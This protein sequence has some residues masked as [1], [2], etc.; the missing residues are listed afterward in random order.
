[1][2]IYDPVAN[3]QI[4]ME[5]ADTLPATTGGFTPVK[6][7]TKGTWFVA[8][9]WTNESFHIDRLPE[10]E[11]NRVRFRIDTHL[12]QE[13]LETRC[14]WLKRGDTVPVIAEAKVTNILSRL[15]PGVCAVV[16]KAL[17]AE[18]YTREVIGQAY[19]L[20]EWEPNDGLTG[21]EVVDME[22]DD[23]DDR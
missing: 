9:V 16:E 10:H 22:A 19:T 14:R 15:D 20:L 3:C 23:A 7:P 8:K 18:G 4:E 6:S 2:K 11:A 17:A 21:V 12:L 1:M 13:R 5:D